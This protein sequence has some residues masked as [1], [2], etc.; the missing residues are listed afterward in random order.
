MR[1]NRRYV[2]LVV[3]LVLAA[4]AFWITQSWLESEVSRATA[5]A[6]ASEKVSSRKILVAAR[7]V[8]PGTILTAEHLEWASWPEDASTE[9]YFEQG[10]TS[11]ESVAGS[12]ARN[13][14]FRGEPIAADAVARPGEGS[15]LSAVL[16]PGYR[17][18]TLD[19]SAS[20]GV[21]G[22]VSPG[23]R[24]DLILSRVLDG[25]GNAKR[26]ISDTVL[27]DVRVVGVDQKVAKPDGEVIAP[28]TATIEVTPA[29]AE[30][31][32]AA[33]ELGKLTLALRSV[34]RGETDDAT[35]DASPSWLLGGGT[36]EQSARAPRR[37]VRRPAPAA[38]EVVRGIN[39]SVE[40]SSR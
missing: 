13:A 10:K 32:V 6:D 7:S 16:R 40:G 36:G 12:V 3:A 24:V 1:N 27:R 14:L 19:V 34:A 17:A 20:T 37:S 25:A 2:Y 38:V 15:V 33:S 8:D 29:Q 21:A 11:L 5:T 22:F 35:S 18:V 28:Q 9:A 30:Q 31:V 4:L 39:S 26:V 23:D